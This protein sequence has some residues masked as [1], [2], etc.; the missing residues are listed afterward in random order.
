M[1]P[2]GKEILKNINVG[3]YLGAKIR[4]LGANKSEKS[5]LMKILA[6]VDKILFTFVILYWRVGGSRCR[7]VQLTYD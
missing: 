6:G 4:F 1:A 3:M 7:G 5:P 2:N